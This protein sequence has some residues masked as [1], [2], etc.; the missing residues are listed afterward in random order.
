MANQQRYCAAANCDNAAEHLFK[1]P[2]HKNSTALQRQAW[3]KF[4]CDKQYVTLKDEAI[5]LVHW[6]MMI[7]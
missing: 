4:V 3:T 6:F 2:E 7:M 1:W 5:R